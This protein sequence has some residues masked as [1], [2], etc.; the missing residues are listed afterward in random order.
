M[1]RTMF[2]NARLIDPESGR[3]GLGCLLVADGVIAAID[4]DGPADQVIDCQGQVLAPG[5][6]DMQVFIGEPGARHKESFRSGGEAAAAGGITTIC[7]QPA[8]DPPLDE[9]AILEFHRRRASESCK[10]RVLP[11]AALTVGREGKMMSEYQFLRDAGAVALTDADRVVADAQV[12]RRCLSYARSVGA[13]VIHHPQEPSLSTGV[14]TEG[15]YASKLGLS[16]S[17][18]VAEAMMLQRDLALVRLTGARYHAD[19]ISTAAGVALIRAAKAEGLPVTAGASI[20]HLALNELDIADYR[21]FMKIR[22]PLRAEEDRAA[23]VQA[24]AEG[25]IDVIHSSHRPQDEESK[26]LPYEQAAP[27]TVG[28]ETL[29]P[30]ALDMVHNGQISLVTLFQRLSLGPARLLGVDGGRLAVGA[31]ADLVWVDIGAPWVVDRHKLLSKCKN[32]AF[33][34]RRVQGRVLGTW[35]AGNRVA[36]HRVA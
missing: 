17:P 32:S 34:R 16:G 23:L 1:M 22:P 25:V 14:A 7:T 19:Q 5:V 12:F 24:V 8:T 20:A 26:R 21:S 10:V 13:L 28:L 6:I 31:R 3:D 9:P 29:L 11:M 36:G 35:V 4:A 18:A 2:T 33:D 15:L 30:V 27:G